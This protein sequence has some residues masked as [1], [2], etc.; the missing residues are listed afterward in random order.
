MQSIERVTTTTEF[1][2][3]TNTP[4][5]YLE[6]VQGICAIASV[7]VTTPPAKTFTAD[8]ATDRL[9]ITSHGFKTGLKGQVST[10]T[11]LP[12]P[13]AATTDY[14]VIVVDANNIKLATT[15]AN[16][17]AGTAIDITDAGAGT[18]T[19]TATALA[20]AS[21]KIQASIDG[22]TWVDVPSTTNAITASATI[23]YNVDRPYYKYARFAYV[24]T[25]GQLSTVTDVL[26][27]GK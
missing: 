21:V 7:T 1:A 23:L 8:P 9:A 6:G 27:K 11:T 20:G 18:H 22:T 25:A 16:A 4:S 19:F 12:A 26:S 17:Q 24:L 2:A 5:T 13:L 3:N 10:T 15:L 14:F